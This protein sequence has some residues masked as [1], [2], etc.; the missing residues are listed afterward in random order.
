M[1]STP[2]TPKQIRWAR[3][4]MTL[5]LVG[6]F[7]FILGVD[8]DLVGLDRSPVVGFVQIGV[9]SVGLAALLLGATLTV[10]VVRNGR[11]NSL[12]SEVG[13]RL[14]AT[15]YVF[16]VAA[17]FADFLGIG[18]HTLPTVYFG[19]IQVLGLALSVTTSLLGLILYWPSRAKRSER[20]RAAT[21]AASAD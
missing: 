18:S 4:W 5:V 3:R 8:P 12:R 17:S 16:A 6:L 1:P 14:I 11:P 21:A 20:T 19:P 10:R 13:L 7:I 9:W 15:G 2:L